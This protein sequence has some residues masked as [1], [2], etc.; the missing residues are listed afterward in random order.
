MARPFLTRCV[1]GILLIFVIAFN[2]P[3]YALVMFGIGGAARIFWVVYHSEKQRLEAE[4]IAAE[5]N[6]SRV[7]RVMAQHRNQMADRNSD[8]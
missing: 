5:S 2:W 3:I 4:S 7:Q 8:Q 1:I 6:T